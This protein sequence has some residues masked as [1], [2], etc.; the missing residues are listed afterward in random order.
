MAPPEILFVS[1][2]GIRTPENIRELAENQVDAV[3][4]GETMMRSGNIAGTL[5]NLIEAGQTK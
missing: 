1:E 5:K 2:S 4:I 3:L